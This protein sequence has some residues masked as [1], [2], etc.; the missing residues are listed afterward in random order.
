MHELRLGRKTT[1]W[2]WFI[3]PQLRGLGISVRAQH[4]GLS[5]ITETQAYLSHP[6]LGAR[7]IDCVSAMLEHENKS[8][9][10]ILGDQDSMK[11]LS[12]LTLFDKACGDENSIFSQALERFYQGIRD[13]YTL[14]RLSH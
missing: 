3:F 8:A 13:A 2:I 7:L 12:C 4:F 6:F 9:T 5:G 11:F 1:H 10:Q 14:Q